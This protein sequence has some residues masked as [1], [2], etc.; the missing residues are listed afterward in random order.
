MVLAL[1]FV[2]IGE[3]ILEKCSFAWTKKKFAM[4]APAFKNISVD[5]PPG[6]LVGVTGFVGSGKSSLLAAILGDMH[7]LEGTMTT[8]ARIPFFCC[9]CLVRESSS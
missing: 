4:E 3:V 9:L 7:L 1:R 2:G 6:S 5:I 8:S